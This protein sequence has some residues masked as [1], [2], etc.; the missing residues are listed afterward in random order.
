MTLIGKVGRPLKV[1]FRAPNIE[2]LHDRARA[3]QFES[4]PMLHSVQWLSLARFTS[5]Q[6]PRR[7]KIPQ[8]KRRGFSIF[9]RNLI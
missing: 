5:A 4:I 7:T 2:M 6:E 8:Q 9:K 3:R 1:T